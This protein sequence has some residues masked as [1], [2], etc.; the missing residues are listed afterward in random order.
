MN[1]L[2]TDS[3]LIARAEERKNKVAHARFSTSE[4]TRIERAAESAGLTVSAFMRSLSLEG[5]GIRPFFTEDDRAI[6][7]LLLSD[8]KA[9]GVN[10]NQLVRVAH[11]GGP[12]RSEERAAIDDVQRVVA[13]LLLELRSFAD[14]GARMRTRPV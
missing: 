14:R 6:L 7:G 4:M 11:R 8:V 1:D 3:S 5:A 2:A 9:V 13:A 12:G 10:L